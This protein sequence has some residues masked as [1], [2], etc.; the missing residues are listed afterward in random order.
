[1]HFLNPISAKF[2]VH[3]RVNPAHVRHHRGTDTHLQPINR[4]YACMPFPKLVN[5]NA[6]DNQGNTAL[7]WAAFLAIPVAARTLLENGAS[8]QILNNEDDNPISQLFLIDDIDFN[9]TEH[10]T[11]QEVLRPLTK[12]TR[13]ARRG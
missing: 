10:Q 1:M 4:L 8:M 6:Q 12:S 2:A 9:I 7:H 13:P 11:Y 5:V 3:Q